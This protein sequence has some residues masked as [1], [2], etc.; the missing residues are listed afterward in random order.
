MV[1]I[2]YSTYGGADNVEW[3]YSIDRDE[4]F[5]AKNPTLVHTLQNAFFLIAGYELEC[6]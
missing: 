5:Y 2:V 6:Q 1:H 3:C 4:R